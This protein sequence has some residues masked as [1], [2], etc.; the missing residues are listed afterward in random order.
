MSH[1]F[2]GGPAS[3]H[4]SLNSLFQIALYLPSYLRCMLWIGRWCFGMPSAGQTARGSAL[5]YISL[6]PVFSLSLSLT[7][8]L[9]LSLSHT[10]TLSLASRSGLMGTP[11]A[12]DK[13]GAR[14]L[15]ARGWWGGR[16]WVERCRRPC[17]V[18]NRATLPLWSL[19]QSSPC[20]NQPHSRKH[21][22]ACG[23]QVRNLL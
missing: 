11:F 5:R 12:S 22:K 8:T 17:L 19:L 23:Q 21:Q 16:V 1:F 2:F 14:W 20:T 3:R 6:D 4:G 7:H 9:S 13:T 15:R 18:A 10:H